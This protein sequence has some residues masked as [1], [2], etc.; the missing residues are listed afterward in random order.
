MYFNSIEFEVVRSYFEVYLSYMK[1]ANGTEI[2]IGDDLER[3]VDGIPNK[4]GYKYTVIGMDWE[5]EEP[6]TELVADGGFIK[7]LITNT[8]ALEYKVI[9]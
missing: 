5:T 7:E 9:Q 1:D 2:K 4:A 8:R 3:I 6:G